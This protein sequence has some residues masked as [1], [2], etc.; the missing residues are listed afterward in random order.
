MSVVHYDKG[1]CFFGT[2][3]GRYTICACKQSFQDIEQNSS[4]KTKIKAKVTCKNCL[5]IIS[6]MK[7]KK[8][9]D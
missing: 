8:V 5:R 3:S 2:V 4:R 6:K 1:D 7:E 9:E